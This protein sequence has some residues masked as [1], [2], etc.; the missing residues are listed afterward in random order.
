M[1]LV[2]LAGRT[3][4]APRFN[5]RGSLVSNQHLQQ[6]LAGIRQML[7]GAHR[8][9]ASMSSASKG[10]E[11]ESFLDGFLAE[12]FPP[13]F[14]FG[15]GD[16]TDSSGHRSGQLDV[17]VELP[18]LPSIPIPGS[19]NRLYLAEGVGAVLR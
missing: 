9:G 12:M 8:A 15:T 2:R 4:I 6:R 1:R 10:G 17:V 11:R 5:E 3:M 19:A 13:P 7:I 14:R 18:F 16:A